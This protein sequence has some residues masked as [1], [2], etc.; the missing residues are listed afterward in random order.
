MTESP[1]NLAIAA[2]ATSRLAEIVQLRRKIHEHEEAAAADWKTFNEAKA[3][4]EEWRKGY[5]TAIAERD[6]ARQEVQKLQN[7]LVQQA[8]LKEEERNALEW[9]K[10]L[11][12]STAY[13][14]TPHRQV[15]TALANRL[16]GSSEKV[17]EHDNES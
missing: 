10:Q 11:M 7:A 3:D 5:H 15:L 14:V 9:L 12:G 17:Y 4:R 13:R 8:T 16:L 2:I 1:E 6:A